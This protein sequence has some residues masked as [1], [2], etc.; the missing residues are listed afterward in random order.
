MKKIQEEKGIGFDVKV[1]QEKQRKKLN[2][3]LDNNG[4][5]RN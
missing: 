2:D 1:L 3:Y 4:I 5:I